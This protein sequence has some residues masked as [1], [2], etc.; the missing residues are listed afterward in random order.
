MFNCFSR[1]ISFPINFEARFRFIV[2]ARY[3]C[4]ALA[5]SN[6]ERSLDTMRARHIFPDGGPIDV[7]AGITQIGKLGEGQ[8]QG[9]VLMNKLGQAVCDE[10]DGRTNPYSKCG[11][12]GISAFTL[13]GLA[14]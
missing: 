2:D 12:R 13:I 4:D 14:A 6:I 3:G 11:W 7:A 10:L 5:P 9:I 1:Q 8:P